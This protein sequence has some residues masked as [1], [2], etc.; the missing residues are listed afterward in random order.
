M[1]TLT[2]IR[3]KVR[4]LTATP[5]AL[6]LP[7]AEIDNYVDD[8]YEQD[9]P[10]ELKLWNLHD[11][12]S[13]YTTAN[14]DRYTLPVN[15]ILGINP[16]AYV[17]GYQSYYTQ[18][19][20]QLYRLYPMTE[21]EQDLGEGTAIA[22]PYIYTLSNTPVLRRTF[23]ASAVDSNDVTRTLV[24]IPLTQSTGNIVA[25]GTTTPSV[26]QIN[27]ETGVIS[28]TF[29]DTISATSTISC[30]YWPYE[31]SRPTAVLFYDDYFILRPV[32]D[33]AYKVTVEAYLSPSQLLNSDDDGP[34]VAQW[35]QLIAFGAALKVLEDRQD[36]ET[37]Q[38]L[39]P[40]YD[41]QK[42]LV[43]HRTILQQTPQRTSTIFTEQSQ[44]SLGNSYRSGY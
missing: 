32:P 6:Q 10:A 4:R 1:T 23:Y 27:Y 14:E 18:N 12:Y 40:R 3:R 28:L 24:D 39:Y 7:D 35:W 30:A 9:M 36:T 17:A 37:I 16:P 44:G 41:E 31:A 21:F 13:F 34:D 8:Y 42:Q 20:E 43:L 38:T 5:S 15:T 22:G 2:K 26:G 19:R 25:E 11:T 29:G 33:K